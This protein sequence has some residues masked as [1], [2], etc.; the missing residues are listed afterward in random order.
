MCE[1]GAQ[2]NRNRFS[3]LPSKLQCWWAWLQSYHRKCQDW[4]SGIIVCAT[5]TSVI[6]LV[7]IPLLII[8]LAKFDPETAI[9]NIFTGDCN[10]VK[11]VN[12]ALHLL[13]N[14]LSTTLL[15]AS[16]YTMQCLNSP[17]R[18]DIDRAHK[19]GTSLHV[20]IPSFRNLFHIEK[21]KMLLWWALCLST[22][23][24]HLL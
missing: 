22:L 3:S 6:A 4:R 10:V 20:G 21:K 14:I 24:L 16:S 15:S 8:A 9:G 1:N 13:I 2:T 18:H 11:K 23:P 17:T 19:Q 7:N 12:S 5:A